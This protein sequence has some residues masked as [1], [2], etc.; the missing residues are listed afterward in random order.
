MGE[1]YKKKIVEKGKPTTKWY[2][3]L[4]KPRISRVLY[5]LDLFPEGLFQR[6][7]FSLLEAPNDKG[8]QLALKEL[9]AR[10]FISSEIRLAEPI[11]AVN[12]KDF[13]EKER[14][15]FKGIKKGF[16]IKKERYFING[17]PFEYLFDI[18]IENWETEKQKK[19]LHYLKQ[20]ICKRWQDNVRASDFINPFT[21]PYD[22][23]G[24]EQAIADLKKANDQKLLDGFLDIQDR[25]KKLK[26]RNQIQTINQL[27]KQEFTHINYLNT[28]IQ[29]ILLE[30]IITNYSKLY[31][32]DKADIDEDLLD[33]ILVFLI[34]LDHKILQATVIP[35]MVQ[36]LKGFNDLIK[37]TKSDQRLKALEKQL[38]E[39]HFSSGDSKNIS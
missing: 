9:K 19:S 28:Q 16:A 14:H 33:T 35:E 29:R 3:C 20:Q 27:R 13:I 26:I 31:F 32:I 6:D 8:I 17:N 4:E 7:I 11:N 30:M 36:R 38:Q 10:G 21:I 39:N 23:E 18:L 22:K 25:L 1:A 34:R 2:T 15:E 37:I 24:E 5:L 12:G